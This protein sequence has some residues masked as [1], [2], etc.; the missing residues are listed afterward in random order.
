MILLLQV[1]ADIDGSFVEGIR[2]WTGCPL[3]FSLSRESG[4][5]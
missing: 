1:E 5:F 2:G 3:S 4:I